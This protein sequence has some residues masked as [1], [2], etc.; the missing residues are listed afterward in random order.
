MLYNNRIEVSEG[1]DVNK[2]NESKEFDICHYCHFLDK[3]IRFQT[4]SCIGWNDLLMMPINFNY[5]A[6]INIKCVDYRNNIN[7]ITKS[8][9]ITL[10]QDVKMAE[11]IYKF[12]IFKSKN[13]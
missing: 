5:I 10:L 2:I 11:K 12:T 1:V 7:I 13:K 6:V 3:E 4:Y 9:A 8:D